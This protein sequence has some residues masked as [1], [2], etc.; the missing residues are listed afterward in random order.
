MNAS[1][2]T[3]LYYNYT[4]RTNDLVTFNLTF[5]LTLTE[6]VTLTPVTLD[7]ADVL[8]NFKSLSTTQTQGENWGD[9]SK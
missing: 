6:S 9:T 2:N 4:E 3:E 8:D 7:S 1:N 5:T